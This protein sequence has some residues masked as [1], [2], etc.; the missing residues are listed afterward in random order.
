MCE[1]VQ[2]SFGLELCL[3]YIEIITFIARWQEHLERMPQ[4]RIAATCS[5]LWTRSLRRPRKDSWRNEGGTGVCLNPVVKN[6]KDKSI[7]KPNS[8]QAYWTRLCIIVSY[9]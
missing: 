4:P 5:P 6:N 2:Y 3:K 9:H 8:E 1:S 7:L